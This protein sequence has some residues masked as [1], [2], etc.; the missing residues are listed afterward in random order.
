MSF[1]WVRPVLP[2]QIEPDRCKD[3]EKLMEIF[4]LFGLWESK[5][6][7][8]LDLIL[9]WQGKK[10]REGGKTDSGEKTE[11]GGLDKY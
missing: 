3:I 11:K 6:L 4:L 9:E 5:K 8:F 1:F 7:N 10:Y 2:H